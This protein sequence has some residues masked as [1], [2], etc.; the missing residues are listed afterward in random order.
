MSTTQILTMG[1]IWGTVIEAGTVSVLVLWLWK[2]TDA[3]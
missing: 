1:Q 2:E 3:V